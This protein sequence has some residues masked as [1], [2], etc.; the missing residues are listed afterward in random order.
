[1]GY[2]NIKENGKKAILASNIITTLGAES[3]SNSIENET[4][5][6]WTY[7]AV[8]IGTNAPGSSDTKLI[9]EIHRVAIGGRYAVNTTRTRLV[10]I[11]GP[12]VAAGSWTE[13][14]IF[15][16]SVN[17]TTISSCDGT[18]NFSSNGTLVQET[19]IV[20]QGVASLQS[21]M[22]TGGTLA[23]RFVGTTTNTHTDFATATSYL[24]FY[25]RSSIDIGTMT[26]KVGP[27]SSNYY[28]FTWAPGT[29]G[30]YSIFHQ[31]FS[32]GTAVGNPEVT[33]QQL[34]VSWFEITHPSYVGTYDEYLDY[35][36]VYSDTG[37]LMAR[38]TISK[39]KSWNSVVNAYYSITNAT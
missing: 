27:N 7:M 31:T 36:S 2:F 32:Q 16:Q 10:G 23:F 13:I 1:M 20:Q 18:A 39:T 25:Y 22:I 21:Q 11:Y 30:V 3:L 9:K 37:L 26:V 19:T 35:V 14:G 38:G 28:Q 12:Y 15:D 5:P 4:G 6:D 8:G 17:R 33:S 24:Q 34:D 29:S